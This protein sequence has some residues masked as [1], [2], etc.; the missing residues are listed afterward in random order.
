MLNGYCTAIAMA[1]LHDVK[2]LDPAAV[3]AADWWPGMLRYASEVVKRNQQHELSA[4]PTMPFHG[5]SVCALALQ[6]VENA[7]QIESQQQLLVTSGVPSALEYTCLHDFPETLLG[8]GAC[9]AGAAVALQG[10]NE[11][12]R[13]LSQRVLFL[14]LDDLAEHFDPEA[15]A[16][17]SRESYKGGQSAGVIA[18]GVGH[19]VAACVVSDTNKRHM[20]E[21]KTLLDALL[22]GLLLDESNHRYGQDGGDTLQQLCAGVL[23]ELSMFGPGAEA[24]RANPAVLTAM[25]SLQQS[26]LTKEAKQSAEATLFQLEGSDKRVAAPDDDGAGTGLDANGQTKP[27]PHIMMSY[28]WDHQD[29]ILRVV[30]WLQAHGYLVWVDTEQMKGSTVD[31][32]A[33]AVEGSEVMLIG[34]SRAYKESS[35]CRMEAQYGLQKKKALIPLK[36]VQGY[37]ADGWLGLLLGTSLWYALYG[38]ALSSEAVFEDRM[39]ALSREIGSR[40]RADAAVTLEPSPVAA[41][42]AD[43]PPATGLKAELEGLRLGALCVRAARTGVEASALD[44]AEASADPKAAIIQLILLEQALLAMP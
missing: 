44:E 19:R 13:A 7:A 22:D 4:Q 14:M 36:L 26:G 27:P 25:R 17:G 31:T 2:H 28:N 40:G 6:I 38:E 43:A 35:N 5:D 32:M 9:A 30:A 39:S 3:V 15:R 29:V 1:W 24:L 10:R 16:G 21:H 12:G 8:V 33:L 18:G 41:T 11:G 42:A 23:E 34:V 20:L 37:E